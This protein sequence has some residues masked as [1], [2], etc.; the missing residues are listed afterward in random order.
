MKTSRLS[1]QCSKYVIARD[2]NTRGKKS[3]L[4]FNTVDE[5]TAYIESVNDESKRNFYEVARHLKNRKPY[6][7]FDKPI[8]NDDKIIS[9]DDF[10][11][12]MT[13]AITDAVL[14]LFNVVID[15]DD[16]LFAN[17]SQKT[18]TGGKISYHITLPD[19]EIS[20]PDMKKLYNQVA[21]NLSETDPINKQFDIDKK[22]IGKLV[23]CVDSAVY[24]KNQLFRLTGCCK[25]GK[26]NT[27]KIIGDIFTFTQSMIG[28][29]DETHLK[30]LST[31][32]DIPL[33]AI[34]P[35]IE[36][37]TTE[38]DIMETIINGLNP[39]RADDYNDWLKITLALGYEKAGIDLALKF[40]S[41]SSKYNV[42]STTDLYNRDAN[43]TK[44]STPSTIGTLLMMLKMD[45][46]EIFKAVLLKIGR[47]KSDNTIEVPQEIKDMIKSITAQAEIENQE[48]KLK[49]WLSNP[50]HHLSITKR[51]HDETVFLRGNMET[52]IYSDRFM[53]EYPT[54]DANENDINTLIIKAPKGGGKTHQIEA[55]ILKH[56]PEYILFL[57]FRRTF[58]QEIVNR[59]SKLDFVLYSD[60]KG[61]ITNKHKRVILQVES[62]GRLEW[63]KK[64]DLLICD[65]I[66][67][68]RT[69]FF[70]PTCRDARSCL[71]KF[72]ML[73]D[74][75]RKLFV[76]DA[77]ISDNTIK[78][79][80]K[81]RDNNILYIENNNTEIQNKFE[82]FYTTKPDKWLNELY[83]AL[84]NGERIAIATSRSIEFQVS[85]K[86]QIEEQYPN[87]KVQLY[88]SQ[89]HT[90]NVEAKE[91][92]KDVNVSWLKYDVI[93]YS[94]T[95]SAGV[96]FDVKHFDTFFGIFNNGAKINSLRQMINRVRT[97]KTNKFYFCLQ[98]FGGN[99][100]PQTFNE[101]ETY[102][103]STRFINQTPE[104]IFTKEKY[105][106]CRVFPHK[107][108]GYYMWIY[109]EIEYS[110][111]NSAFIYN[112][113]KAQYNSGV[114]SMSWIPNSDEIKQN[115]IMKQFKEK[116]VESKK[117]KWASISEALP[118]TMDQR[119]AIRDKLKKEVVIPSTDMNSFKRYN[120]LEY[121]DIPNDTTINTAFVKEFNNKQIKKAYNIRKKLKNHKLEGVLQHEKETYEN[122]IIDSD[123]HVH[124]DLQREYVGNKLLIAHELLTITGFSGFDD[125]KTLSRDI[126]WENIEKHSELLASKITSVCN[127]F[128]RQKRRH[129]KIQ[130]MSLCCSEC[131]EIPLCDDCIDIL[132]N[133]RM[134]M[135]WN[136]RQSMDF[137]NNI[138]S[139]LLQLKIKQTNRHSE[140]Y[141]IDGIDLFSFNKKPILFNGKIIT[142]T[143]TNNTIT[144]NTVFY[145]SDDSDD[146]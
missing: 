18:K 70:S 23:S 132:K 2:E 93:I 22:N 65:E 116:F 142:M 15:A 133:K 20:I 108:Q 113:I 115:D 105:N 4:G 84:T 80:K 82:E 38:C 13:D 3:Y 77:D 95:I 92:L 78:L 74:S 135:S 100:K 36:H 71:S 31:S 49:K 79:I 27:K 138:L 24:G 120:L 52:E 101:M 94:P 127:V 40:A 34:T 73:T 106:G 64:T 83:K 55:Y 28:V 119:D 25:F 68:L 62:L 33:A 141:Y 107:N 134:V 37:K 90:T 50:G 41:Q 143:N 91:D 12:Y 114:G 1:Q 17:S 32:D 30:L 43:D 10:V 11:L 129:P 125:S 130:Q 53:K 42:K 76:S 87:I 46:A 98:S 60:I 102:I 136:F 44:C 57:S 8:I 139:E 14:S 146:E 29:Y 63:T 51:E 145:D 112:F 131:S 58:S 86:K 103:T 123:E 47:T 56:N 140:V 61:G 75:A 66:E 104:Y 9:T 122:W 89:I 72:N 26:S 7:D 39:A 54:T 99:T 45:N 121:Y 117:E 111:D 81:A 109:N 19:Y 137:I 69:Q 21:L 97:F 96:S 126:M 124:D 118:I 85:L 6:F 48:D 88:N 144:N 67:S 35:V 59:L 16:I 5:I 128:G 110:R